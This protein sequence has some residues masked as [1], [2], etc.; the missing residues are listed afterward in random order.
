MT[1]NESAAAVNGRGANSSSRTNPN[2]STSHSP[3]REALVD[4]LLAGEPYAI[5]FGVQ[6][7]SWLEI[8]EEITRD[9]G[10][11]PEITA[12]VLQAGFRIHEV[13]IAYNPRRRDEGKKVSWTDGLDAVYTL[14]RCR[15]IP[16]R[17]RPAAS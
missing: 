13:P 1:I 11:E 9:N 2:G 16:Q 10:I 5:A 4:R 12:R 6:G 3:A 14:L 7:A 17:G 8:L 15:F